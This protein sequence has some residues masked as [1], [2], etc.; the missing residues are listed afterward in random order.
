MGWTGESPAE[1]VREATQVNLEVYNVLGQRVL[2]LVDGGL[3]PGRHQVTF[4]AD[5]LP[6]GVYFYHIQMGSYSASRKMVLLR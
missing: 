2:T 3:E 4:E 6:T 5:R 1:S